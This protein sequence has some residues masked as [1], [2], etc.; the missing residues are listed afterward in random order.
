MGKYSVSCAKG[1]DKN[2]CVIFGVGASI[3]RPLVS[4]PPTATDGQWPPP[5]LNVAADSIRHCEKSNGFMAA[6]SRRYIRANNIDLCSGSKPPPYDKNP[7][8]F[9]TQKGAPRGQCH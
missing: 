2:L 4:T 9:P 8:N 7:H 5:T 1:T 3:A 6:D